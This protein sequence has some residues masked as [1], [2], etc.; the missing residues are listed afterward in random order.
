[1]VASIEAIGDRGQREV[2][3]HAVPVRLPSRQRHRGV[4]GRQNSGALCPFASMVTEDATTT[5]VTHAWRVGS[6]LE[7]C[8]EGSPRTRCFRDRHE[9]GGRDARAARRQANALWA[10]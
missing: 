7:A 1:M 2:T 9:G 8:L 3:G 6:R 10:D 5:M 4:K